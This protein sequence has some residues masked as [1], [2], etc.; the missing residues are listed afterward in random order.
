MINL[1]VNTVLFKDFSFAEAARA[2]KM[3]GYDGLE[4][5]A[6]KGMCEHLDPERYREQKSEI[7]EILAETGLKILA[8]EVASQDEQRLELAFAAAAELGIPVINVGPTGKSG[9]EASLQACIA[10]L[11]RMSERAA[12]YGVTLCC[13]AHVGASL[14]NTPTTLQAMAAISSPSFGIDMDP[15]H[16][17]RSGVNPE[18]ALPAVL[19]R[20][21]HIHIRD[22]RGRGPSPGD[23]PLQACG[24]GDINLYGYFQAMVDGHYSGPV[25][26]EI[27]GPSQSLQQATVIAAE[28]YGY[29]NACL[30]KLAAR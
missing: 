17:Y 25:D 6:I 12:T 28:S 22:C 11:K 2:I 26:L 18:D 3:A 13:K 10:N 23:P 14:Y 20:T 27:I 30:K 19:S 7:L 5:C 1:G 4:I 16:I 15:S 21:R 9:D 24:R 8:S 29:M